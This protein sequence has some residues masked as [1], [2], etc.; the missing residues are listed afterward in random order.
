[1]FWCCAADNDL[2]STSQG[3]V[4]SSSIV[5]A[6]SITEELDSKPIRSEELAV[7]EQPVKVVAEPPT[8]VPEPEKEVFVEQD[9][10]PAPVVAVVE[11]P[12]LQPEPETAAQPDPE[13]KLDALPP[14]ELLPMYTISI[15]KTDHRSFGAQFDLTD[16][17]RPVIIKVLPDTH[18]SGGLPGPCPTVGSA[19]VSVNDK[20]EDGGSMVRQL[21]A[22]GPVSATFKEPR[23]FN[24]VLP[25]GEGAHGLDLKPTSSEELGLLVHAVSGRAT[26]TGLQVRDFIF[27]VNGQKNKPQELYNAIVNATSDI[28]LGV[29]TYNEEAKQRAVL[30]PQGDGPLGLEMKEVSKGVPTPGLYV[31]TSSGR[32]AAAGVRSRDTI[33]GVNGQFIAPAAMFALLR[34]GGKDLKLAITTPSS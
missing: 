25:K 18:L 11:E 29:L 15:S 27:E 6:V 31:L 17:D 30:V 14:D 20:V 10:Q 7:T 32:A 34:A 28:K 33:I 9:N 22:S 19:L 12:Q 2:D 8:A 13:V 1:M 5:D 3:L 21:R 16:S 23:R 24:V 4:S 26:Q